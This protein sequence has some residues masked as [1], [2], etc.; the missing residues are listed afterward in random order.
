VLDLP[1]GTFT[2]AGVKT[3]VL[4]FE[5]GKPTQKTWFYQLNLNR[6]L[7]K[8]NPLNEKDLEDFIALQ[9]TQAESENSWIIDISDINQDTFDLSVK[10]PNALEQAPLRSPEEI[11]KEMDKLDQ[12]SKNILKTIKGLL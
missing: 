8:T 4:F 6:N 12:Q 1:G 5:K 2:G 7:G 10:N 9:K 3:V 11:L